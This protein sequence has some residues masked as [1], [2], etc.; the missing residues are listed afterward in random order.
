MFN[1]PDKVMA[2][3]G[4]AQPEDLAM[5][6]KASLKRTKKTFGTDSLSSLLNKMPEVSIKNI[7]QL[8][9]ETALDSLAIE[10]SATGKSS[11]ISSLSVSVNGVPRLVPMKAP[12]DAASV[13]V[14]TY[15]KLLPGRN[16]ISVTAINSEGVSSLPD[17]AEVTYTGA[18]ERPDLY[19]V[20][21]AINQYQDQ[22]LNLRYAVKDARDIIRYMANDKRY[23]K[24]FV[25]SLFNTKV[26]LANV[27]NLKS[28]LKKA[29]PQDMVIVFFA[30][31]GVL[32]QNFDFR[33][34]T[35]G[36]DVANPA[37]T[38]VL[39]DDIEN[40]LAGIR[41]RNKLLL[42]D[43]CHSGEVDKDEILQTTEKLIRERNGGERTVVTQSFG[44]VHHN[45]FESGL[46]DR[47][48]FELMQELFMASSSKTGA[49]VVVATAG[50]SYAIESADW[51]N[52]FFTYA[53]LNGLKS[54]VA[55]TNQDRKITV[56]EMVAYLRGE[57]KQMSQGKQ[58]P[59]FR[60]ENPDNYFV[61]FEK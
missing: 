54:G 38:A 20:A 28:S 51:Q 53:L 21:V 16:K 50:D 6:E 32:D 47:S 43:A 5:L 49:Q 25:D 19:L 11:V 41:A 4:F 58:V 46:V 27:Q 30:G 37:A 44:K 9:F 26:T 60:E 42:V 34:G 29:R 61:V 10:I 23:R 40:L 36:L 12:K 22:S 7:Q 13:S 24:V 18:I 31:H 3:S 8:P 48:G 56:D 55:D 14:K 45:V 39:Y 57:V 35:W 52:G 59:R 2:A 17:E 15:V 33:F 1:R